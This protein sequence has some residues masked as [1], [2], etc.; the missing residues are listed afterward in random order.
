[1]SIIKSFQS[2]CPYLDKPHSIAVECAEVNM[3]GTMDSHYK[4][5]GYDCN[6]INECPYPSKDKYGRCPVY[7][8]SLSHPL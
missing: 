3:C 2:Q 4:R 6:M 7:L 8:E 5:I 1:M